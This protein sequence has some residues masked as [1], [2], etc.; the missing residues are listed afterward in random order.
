[1][2]HTSTDF[3]RFAPDAT[4]LVTGAAGG[5]GL[6]T[7]R[8]LLE[9]GLSVIGLD[10]NGPAIES[11]QLG[12][13]F[14]GYR[15][16]TGDRSVVEALLP[17][18]RERHG[19]IAHLV[20]NA[21]PPSATPLSIEEGLART[22]GAFQFLT[23]A[24]LALDP[25]Q[26]ASVVNVASC[27][28]VVS[29]GPPPSLGVAKGAAAHN[30]WYP[31][32]KAAVAGLTRF[33]AVSAAGRYRANCVAPSV[34]DTPRMAAHRDGAYGKLMCERNPLGRLG[35]AREVACTIAFLLSPAASYVNGAVLIVDGGGT[36][37]F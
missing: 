35:T 16:D 21:G 11:L 14:T 17:K 23:A 20:N 7:T 18:L 1:M 10:I 36:L 5:I 13:R 15:A 4:A 29:G 9:Q 3:L 32:G 25:P 33:Q 22:A 34:I 37:V 28:G 2:S 30:G 19:P 8:L 6:E 12:P 24:W 26:D 31:V 27:A